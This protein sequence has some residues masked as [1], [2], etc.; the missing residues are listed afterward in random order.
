VSS[1][2]W[3]LPP[4][5]PLLPSSSG[6]GQTTWTL[7]EALT[8]SPPVLSGALA[9]FGR[10]IRFREDFTVTAA[11]DWATVDG[12]DAVKQS[13]LNEAMTAPDEFALRPEYGMGLADAVKRPSS[14][15]VTDALTNRVRDRLAKNPR[16]TKVKQVAIESVAH[17]GG[18]ALRVTIRVE[19]A[20]RDLGPGT[21]LDPLVIGPGGVV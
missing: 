16:V 12:L 3:T 20:G 5:T 6:L 9:M 2:S 15:S 18:A 19:A 1:F 21:G 17:A 8:P 11:K 4:A 10:D 7:P 13:I 14:R